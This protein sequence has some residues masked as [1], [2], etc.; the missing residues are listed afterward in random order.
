MNGGEE[1]VA[2]RVKVGTKASGTR[3]K[4]RDRRAWVEGEQEVRGGGR[5]RRGLARKES[6]VVCEFVRK[7]SVVSWVSEGR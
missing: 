1:D 5:R 2:R 4:R 6:V 7:V 3:W